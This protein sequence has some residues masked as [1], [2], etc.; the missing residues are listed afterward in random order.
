MRSM[1]TLT[2][3]WPPSA[4]RLWRN[5][6]GRT[7]KSEVYRK[8]LQLAGWDLRSQKPAPVKGRYRLTMIAVRPDQRRRDLDNLLKPVSDLLKECGVIEDDSL[9][10]TVM[11]GWSLE[12]PV[13]DG[14][15]IVSVE[16][17]TDAIPMLGK[18]A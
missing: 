12:S 3:P 16:A 7:I 15:I 4:N 14:L 1:T 2:L 5:V 18:A 9:A 6:N 17:F 11:A 10:Q 8:W 13:H